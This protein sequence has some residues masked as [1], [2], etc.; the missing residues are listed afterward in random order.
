MHMGFVCKA[1]TL[2]ICDRLPLFPRK[3][4]F[5]VK[6]VSNRKMVKKGSERMTPH[7]I[8]H[9]AIETANTQRLKKQQFV[10]INLISDHG[11]LVVIRTLEMYILWCVTKHLRQC[12][13]ISPPS[14]KY[15][16]ER[17]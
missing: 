4:S 6:V 5:K 2:V 12:A 9:M 7:P 14:T 1:N 3:M 10:L 13:I 15:H 11:R 16:P 17:Q 8:L